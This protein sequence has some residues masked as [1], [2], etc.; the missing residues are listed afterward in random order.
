M[1]KLLACLALLLPLAAQAQTDYLID[2]DEVGEETIG[3][4]IDLVRIESVNPPGNETEV[5]EYLRGVLAK[6]GID[7]ELFALDPAR[8]NLV[9]RYEGNGTKAPILIMG[10]T[11]VVGVQADKW[12][13]PP[14]SGLRKDGYIW[15]RGT[16]DDKDKH[17]D[18]GEDAAAGETGGAR[19]RRS[20]LQAAAG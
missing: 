14:F 17:P 2:W 16:L 11:D 8:A 5:A 13:Q 4:L 6:E 10:H 19:D 15:G 12:A 18:H 1:P 9:A 3:Y 7:S 20:R